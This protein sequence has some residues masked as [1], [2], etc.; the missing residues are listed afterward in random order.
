QG[1][2]CAWGSCLPSIEATRRRTTGDST[3]VRRHPQRARSRRRAPSSAGGRGAGIAPGGQAPCAA[4]NV[5]ELAIRAHTAP[6]ARWDAFV[7]DCPEATF[8][9]RAAWRSVLRSAFGHRP[10]FLYAESDGK[11]R[12]VLPLAR[13]RSV[14]L[15][16][17]L[18]ST[19]FCVYGGVAA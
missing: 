6:V 4:G 11:I 7:S 8:F 18:I 9:H 1:A 13:Q 2:G 16:D 5:S 17:A 3:R 15:G 14:L 10:Y 12:G 19:P